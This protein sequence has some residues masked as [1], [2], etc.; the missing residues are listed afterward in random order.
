MDPFLS[1]FHLILL[2]LPFNIHPR[3]LIV[4]GGL[5]VGPS[6]FIVAPFFFIHVKGL[7]L[8]RKL[9]LTFFANLSIIVSYR[10]IRYGKINL[11]FHIF[12]GKSHLPSG[13]G[14]PVSS[15][16]LFCRINRLYRSETIFAT[17]SSGLLAASSSIA[18]S[19]SLYEIAEIM[20]GSSGIFYMRWCFVR[21]TSAM[22]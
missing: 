5:F 4:L 18:S 16:R 9:L 15:F 19:R 17:S 20:S 13:I 6:I 1:A 11:L 10:L 12:F 22:Q 14:R 8:P 3:F 2:F 7:N 21:S